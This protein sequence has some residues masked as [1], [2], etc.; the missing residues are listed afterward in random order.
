MIEGD[1]QTWLRHRKVPDDWRVPSCL[2]CR[3]SRSLK[4]RVASSG[5]PGQGGKCPAS[6]RPWTASS[7]RERG[8]GAGVCVCGT[9]LGRVKLRVGVLLWWDSPALQGRLRLQPATPPSSP[10]LVP[11]QP[12]W[13]GEAPSQS[14]SPSLWL[15]LPA[16]PSS[17]LNLATGF[18]PH[19]SPGPK[20]GN[21]PPKAAKATCAGALGSFDPASRL[22]ARPSRPPTILTG[23]IPEMLHLGPL[24]RR[25]LR[26]AIPGISL[27]QAVSACPEAPASFSGN[28]AQERTFQA[29]ERVQEPLSKSDPRRVYSE[30]PPVSP[31]S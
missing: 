4:K 10:L 19:L 28:H 17:S 22:P 29:R 27:A 13:E 3:M 12:L 30:V 8:G 11:P 20:V 25:L 21:A 5:R 1:I 2:M 7:L 6:G 31:Y 14:C 18:R 15:A 9:C 16:G 24:P 26:G 23:K